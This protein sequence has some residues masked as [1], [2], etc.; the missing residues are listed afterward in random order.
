M[1][2]DYI[3]ASL[4]EIFTPFLIYL[5]YFAFVQ[6]PWQAGLSVAVVLGVFNTVAYFFIHK[7]RRKL[8]YAV[9]AIFSLV[10]GMLIATVF[11]KL[12]VNS[13]PDNLIIAAVFTLFF[14]VKTPL[15]LFGSKNYRLTVGIMWVVALFALTVVMSVYSS[16]N[17]LFIESAVM[18]AVAMSIMFGEV[19]YFYTED[20]I[21]S[22]INVGYVSVYYIILAVVLAIVSEGD[23]LGDCC[24]DGLSGM[25]DGTS[26]K[27]KN[28]NLPPLE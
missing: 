16:K 1:K 14:V 5:T 25:C 3:K 10:I 8:L 4:T 23:C 18:S 13:F 12:K 21:M 6:L 28:N 9:S 24:D 20:N 22:K 26:K 27:N 17:T 2:K 19:R 11:S 15:L 7:K